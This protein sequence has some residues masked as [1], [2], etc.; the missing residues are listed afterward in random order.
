MAQPGCRTEAHIDT[1]QRL[2]CGFAMCCLKPLA[3]GSG[4]AQALNLR[5]ELAQVGDSHDP[6]GLCQCLQPH[7]RQDF[8][9]F[10]HLAPLEVRQALVDGANGFTVIHRSTP[11]LSSISFTVGRVTVRRQRRETLVMRLCSAQRQG[12][13]SLGVVHHAERCGR[14]STPPHRCRSQSGLHQPPR[15][16]RGE[17]I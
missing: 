2:R 16:M 1:L 15:R 11:H 13:R 10:S 9:Y 5:R 17:R 7:F 8:Q 3:D 14:G 4:A 6:A 12:V